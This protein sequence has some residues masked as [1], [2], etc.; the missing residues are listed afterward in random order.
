MR[1]YALMML[2]ALLMVGCR[3]SKNSESASKDDIEKVTGKEATPVADAIS[4]KLKLK[5]EMDDKSISCGGTYRLL[6]D[7]VVQINLTYTVV[8]VNVNVGTLEITRDSILILDR[9]NKRYCRASFQEM[10]QLRS[11]GIDFGVLQSFFWGDAKLGSNAYVDCK[12]NSWAQLTNRQVPEDVTLT[13]DMPNGSE[14]KANFVL[15][16]I[17]ETD[18]WTHRT[19]IPSN[20]DSVPFKTVVNA[21]QKLAQ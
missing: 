20:Y 2:L 16:K 11:A 10:Y 7:D 17:Q 8:L 12:Y 4:A 1:K 6:R 15:S 3:S 13:F 19:E 21:L 9:M 14:A 18:D 5:M